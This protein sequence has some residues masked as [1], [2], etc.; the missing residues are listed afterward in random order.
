MSYGRMPSSDSKPSSL[1][2]VGAAIGVGFVL[3]L[4]VG[5]IALF[6][7]DFSVTTQPDETKL[8]IGAG[9]FEDPKMKDCIPAST[10]KNTITNDRYVNYPTSGRDYDA[11]TTN[12]ADSGPIT[13]LSKD[14]AEMSVPVRVTW[15][16]NTDCEAL[17]E[18]YGLYNRYGAS[19]DDDG[20]TTPGWTT[21]L[22]KVFLNTLDTTL[23]EVAKGFTWRELYNDASA[24]NALQAALDE[25][26]QQNV[27]QA[28]KGEFFVN[29]DVPTLKKP[30]PT[31]DELAAAIEAEQAAVAGA[32]SAE[33][34]ARAQKLQAE[35]EVAV[36]RAEAAKRRAEID[37][38]GGFEN[39]AKF[40]AVENGINPWQPS[41]GPPITPVQ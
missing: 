29:I 9:P 31:N 32:Q 39:Y 25:S 36:S 30:T 16:F 20:K 35:A 15:D 6:S 24:Q 10:K 41:Y 8:Q 38:F 28:A 34:K 2:K 14:N 22:D 12:G 26:L 27:N 23:D 17:K 21:V 33:A 4:I 3:L 40:K 11:G 19:L 1:A 7:A 5:V 13:V 37:G 18:F